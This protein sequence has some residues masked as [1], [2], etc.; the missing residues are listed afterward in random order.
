MCRR[1]GSA[2]PELATFGRFTDKASLTLTGKTPVGA[3]VGTSFNVQNQMGVLSGA[4]TL[5][6]S[7]AYTGPMTVS[8]R[9]GAVP[10][11]YTN[12]RAILYANLNKPEEPIWRSAHQSVSATFVPG[13]IADSAVLERSSWTIRTIRTTYLD[14]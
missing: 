14:T 3:A 11:L 5:C 9:I 1:S 4:V 13:I 12:G 10:Y 2:Q 6:I 7:V 8:F